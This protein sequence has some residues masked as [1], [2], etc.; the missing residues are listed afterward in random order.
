[1]MKS[2][3]K[4]PVW[5]AVI[6]ASVISIAGFLGS[7]FLG[8]WPKI[9]SS[10]AF[11]WEFLTASSHVPHW[12]LGLLFLGFAPTIFLLLVGIWVLIRGDSGT[13]APWTS[14]TSDN[15]FG[16]HW[17]WRYVAGDISNLN[18]FCPNCDFQV[19]PHQA[20]SYDFI[21]RIGFSCDSCKISLGQHEESHAQLNSKVK[22]FIQQKLRN[23]TWSSSNGT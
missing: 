13:P 20:S 22:R 12:V 9:T 6:A 4:D 10:V 8:Y 7:Y 17:R 5:S 19:F 21:D 3:W 18:S 2:I 1:M 11:T 15:F 14:Y 16:L 23:D